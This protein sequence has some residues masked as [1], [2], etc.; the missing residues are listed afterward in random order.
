[1]PSPDR[2]KSI[3]TNPRQFDEMVELVTTLMK[4]ESCIQ[5]KDTLERMISMMILEIVPTVWLKT[6][7]TSKPSKYRDMK[8]RESHI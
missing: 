3:E 7:M 1:M 8:I 6:P 4:M 2:N 5:L